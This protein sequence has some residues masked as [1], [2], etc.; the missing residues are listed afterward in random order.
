[1]ASP[2]AAIALARPVG[3]RL[4]RFQGR[5]FSRS[6]CCWRSFGDAGDDDG[7]DGEVDV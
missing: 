1:M 7:E 2:E 3:L 6:C 5:Y 4:L